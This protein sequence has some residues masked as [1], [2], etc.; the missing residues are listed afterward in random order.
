M[1]NMSINEAEYKRLFGLVKGTKDLITVVRPRPKIE[2]YVNRKYHSE[3]DPK[4]FRDLLCGIESFQGR[5]VKFDNIF[6]E[7]T[8]SPLER[9]A[10]KSIGNSGAL[11]GFGELLLKALLGIERNSWGYLCQD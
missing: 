1:R 2:Q 10:W 11:K 4:A 5:K 7:L 9:I 6:V 8:V 3:Y